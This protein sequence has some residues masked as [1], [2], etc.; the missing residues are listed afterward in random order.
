M[1]IVRVELLS[2]RTKRQKAEL[3]ADI[4]ALFTQRL[5]LSVADTTVILTNVD[6]KDW[7]AGIASDGKGLN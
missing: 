5:G 2:G 3:A 1:P 7:H 4:A 6:Q